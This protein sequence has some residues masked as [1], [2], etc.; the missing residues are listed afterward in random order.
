MT[1]PDDDGTAD[2]EV[3]AFKRKRLVGLWVSAVLM[4]VVVAAIFYFV[5]RQ[6]LLFTTLNQELSL[7]QKCDMNK[8]GLHYNP[9]DQGQVRGPTLTTQC[10]KV[11]IKLQRRL[12]K[13]PALCQR[14]AKMIAGEK[15]W[16]RQNR[17]LHVLI[18]NRRT[19]YWGDTFPTLEELRREPCVEEP[20]VR[21]AAHWNQHRGSDQ[22]PEGFIPGLAKYNLRYLN[23]IRFLVTKTYVLKRVALPQPVARRLAAHVLRQYRRLN[24]GASV[25][26]RAEIKELFEKVFYPVWTKLGRPE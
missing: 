16:D 15:S 26:L 4:V 18:R 14:I 20:V 2:A 17:L 23:H 22:N 5:N 7:L 9:R 3:A 13:R 19:E 10:N 24:A 21:L 6:A 11:I 12:R 8:K 1:L 25:A